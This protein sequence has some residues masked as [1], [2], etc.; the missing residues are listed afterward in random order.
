MNDEVR[1][2]SPEGARPG[3]S[4]SQLETRV[5]CTDLFLPLTVSIVTFSIIFVEDLSWP[6]GFCK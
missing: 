6:Y 2:C 3:P 5:E 1:V 4:K